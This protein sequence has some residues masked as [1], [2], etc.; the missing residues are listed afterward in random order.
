MGKKMHVKPKRKRRL[1]LPA[2]LSQAQLK[3]LM[4]L[5]REESEIRRK[6][7]EDAQQMTRLTGADYSTRVY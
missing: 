6:N 1:R 7:W 2:K 4:T 5:T 3:K